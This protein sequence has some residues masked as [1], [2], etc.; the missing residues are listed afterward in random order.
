MNE[1]IRLNE[2]G[3]ADASAKMST[4]EQH[5]RTANE[6]LGKAVEALSSAG[7][8]ATADAAANMLT[9]LGVMGQ[10]LFESSGTHVS[11][12]NAAVSA[13]VEADLMAASMGGGF[14]V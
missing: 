6:S 11:M 7:K 3:A 5:L 4:Q 10:M 8:G 14:G 9:T 2:A 1:E 13:I 12:F